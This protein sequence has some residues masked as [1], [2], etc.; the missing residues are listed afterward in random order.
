MTSFQV[1]W[2]VNDEDQDRGSV[3]GTPIILL[4]FFLPLAVPDC[5]VD[6]YPQPDTQQSAGGETVG[7][8]GDAGAWGGAHS[9]I[10]YLR[11]TP[12]R[13]CRRDRGKPRTEPALGSGVCPS[14]LLLLGIRG[15]VLR[16]GDLR[17]HFCK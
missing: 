4:G 7:G 16:K 11:H 9:G 17:Y 13:P 8:V 1:G 5:F 15:G 2:R 12:G 10:V 3:S 14:S 6:V